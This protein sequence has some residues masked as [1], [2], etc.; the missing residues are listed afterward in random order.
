MACY[1]IGAPA[2]RV[3]GYNKGLVLNTISAVDNLSE[4]I[5]FVKE[6]KKLDANN[7]NE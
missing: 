4:I 3:S 7:T 5:Q 2:E 1:N 6:S